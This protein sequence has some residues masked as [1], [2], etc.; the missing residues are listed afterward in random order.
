[1]LKWKSDLD[2]KRLGEVNSH[3]SDISRILVVAYKTINS[4]CSGGFNAV[5]AKNSSFS[6]SF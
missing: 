6:C 4:F 1:M 2:L 3:C 5:R